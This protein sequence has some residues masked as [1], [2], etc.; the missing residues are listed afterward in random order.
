MEDAGVEILL[1]RAVDLRGLGGQELDDEIGEAVSFLPG[2]PGIALDS[3]FDAADVE[4]VRASEI[5]AA[6]GDVAGLLVRVVDEHVAAR[7]EISVPTL[8]HRLKDQVDQEVH[9][10]DVPVALQ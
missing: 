4:D 3:P 10:D 8:A 5:R 9:L 1:D 2:H 7:E 6:G